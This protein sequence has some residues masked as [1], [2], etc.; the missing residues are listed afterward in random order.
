[1]AI[2]QVKDPQGVMHEISG[3]DGATPDEVIAQAQR[4]PELNQQ[5]PS[6]TEQDTGGSLP[7]IRNALQSEHPV[8]NTLQVPSQMAQRGLSQLS[9]EL[10]PNPEYTGN[11]ARDLIKNYP[12]MSADVLSKVAP[13]FIDRTSLLTAGASQA[14]KGTVPLA[15]AVGSGIAGQLEQVAG[16]APGAVSGAF[17]DASLIFSPGKKTAGAVYEAGKTGGK[18]AENLANIPKKDEFLDI[19]S[20]LADEGKLPPETALEGRKIAGKLLSKGGGSYT[21]DYLRGLVSKFDDIA[22]SNENIAKADSIYSRGVKAQSLRNLMP[23][24]KYGGASAFK[25]GIITA[26]NEMGMSGRVIGALMSPLAVGAGATALG[27]VARPL[28]TI[29]TNPAAAVTAG[30][31]SE[32]ISRIN[33]K[34]GGQ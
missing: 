21:E 30:V 31:I 7:E 33:D 25:M 4:M 20:K 3:P 19:A 18:M 14:I 8:W 26:L 16:T 28:G 22:K 6:Q 5:P 24:N 27:A 2:Y 32:Y 23:Q 9:E 1:M 13:S 12:S 34:N 29:I 17:K 10:K 11:M 15:K